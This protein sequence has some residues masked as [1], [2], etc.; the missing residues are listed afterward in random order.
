MVWDMTKPDL[1]RPKRGCGEAVVGK[2]I[3]SP[4]GPRPQSVAARVSRVRRRSSL[5]VR[6]SSLAKLGF[7][8]ESMKGTD[9][10]GNSRAREQHL[11]RIGRL[12]IVLQRQENPQAPKIRAQFSC[13]PR[14]RNRRTLHRIFLGGF[15]PK[16]TRT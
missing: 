15:M 7:G 6:D 5:K 12:Y 10:E 4:T 2:R 8:M 16:T 9:Q 13:L 14:R 11:P 3:P 1:R